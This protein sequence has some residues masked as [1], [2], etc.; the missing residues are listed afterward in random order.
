MGQE[1]TQS[2]PF[3]TPNHPYPQHS[4]NI[5]QLFPMSMP[6]VPLITQQP[7]HFQNSNSPQPT[8]LPTQPIPSK[9]NKTTQA[10][11]SIEFKT[12]PSYV[13]STPPMD[14]IQFRSGRVVNDKPKSSVVIHEEDEEEEDTKKVMNDE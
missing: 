11:N 13:I 2:P 12:L 9:K 1:Y 3:P 14:G 6:P 7:H 10:L 8:L 4:P 5:Q